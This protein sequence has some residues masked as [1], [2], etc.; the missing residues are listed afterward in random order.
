PWFSPHFCGTDVVFTAPNDIIRAVYQLNP[1]VTILEGETLTIPAGTEHV[2]ENEN[3]HFNVYGS[4]VLDGSQEQP[5]EITKATGN[6]WGGID[7]TDG[8]ITI[9]HSNIKNA[10]C[11]GIGG[12]GDVGIIFSTFQDISDFLI[13][14]DRPLVVEDSYFNNIGSGLRVSSESVLELHRSTLENMP[15]FGISVED[16]ILRLYDSEIR[17]CTN[18]I[19]ITDPDNNITAKASIISS[20]I[21]GSSQNSG[22]GVF[23]QDGE[24]ENM[25][26]SQI[27]NFNIGLSGIFQYARLR[28]IVVDRSTIAAC[29]TGLYWDGAY[30]TDLHLKNSIISGTSISYYI[31]SPGYGYFSIEYNDFYPGDP[32]PENWIGSSGNIGEDPLFVDAANGNFNLLEESPC[33]DSG[34]PNEFDPDGTR[35][36][37]G[38]YYYDHIPGTP[39]LQSITWVS[40][41]PKLTWTPPSDLDIQKF[42]IHRTYTNSSGTIS[43]TK[44]VGN[45]VTTWIDNDITYA[46]K[47][48]DTRATYKVK[49]VDN[50]DQQ[51]T[52]SNSRSVTGD[53]IIMLKPT[54]EIPKN[55]PK[56]FALHP[57]YPNPFNPTTNIQ[58]DLP[59]D[60]KFSLIIY[61][62]NGKEVWRL[63]NQRRNTYPAGYHTILWDG[64]NNFGSVVPT[65]VYFIVYNSPEYKLTQKV[66]LMK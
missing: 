41:H 64:R 42:V 7:V 19:K 36:D 53:G 44:D 34:N 30:K 60:T 17:N 26:L 4:L 14:V 21:I 11:I 28:H 59:K 50:I 52:Y 33:I 47:F 39:Y 43:W 35:L 63:N 9:N 13:N 58:I 25:E 22:I 51:S 27:S 24:I 57:A 49:T 20:K 32:D 55:I 2:V 18:G 65:G 40:S 8:N 10:D 23:I 61:D 29:D 54:T 5:V 46:P 6:K 1:S 15:D 66:V 45:N 62:I 3:Y 48:G 38:A 37:I 12:G 31:D 16:G 56:E